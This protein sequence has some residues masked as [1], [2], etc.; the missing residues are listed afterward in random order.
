MSL[1]MRISFCIYIF[2]YLCT[3]VYM[4]F[5]LNDPC[6]PIYTNASFLQN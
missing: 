2:V 4:Y 6:Q 3:F 1:C 5:H